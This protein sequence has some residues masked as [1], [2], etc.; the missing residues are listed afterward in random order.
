[1]PSS[2]TASAI[3][4][5]PVDGVLTIAFLEKP[6]GEGRFLLLQ[7]DL[8]ATLKDKAGDYLELDGKSRS[9]RCGIDA[10]VVHW[11]RLRFILNAEGR[12]RIGVNEFSVAHELKLV[13]LGRLYS[14]LTRIVGEDRVRHAVPTIE[15]VNSLLRVEGDD[16]DAYGRFDLFV[17]AFGRS[18]AVHIDLADASGIAPGSAAVI[19]D[20]VGMR[21][22]ARKKITQ[23]LHEH[24]L[25]TAREV[26]FPDPSIAA[27]PP[28][29]VERMLGRA[30]KKRVVAL[31]VDDPIHPCFL[32]HGIDSVEKK[33]TWTGFRISETAQTASR[34][35]VL[36]CRPQ[37]EPEHGVAIVIRDG[38]AVAA[39]DADVNVGDFDR[40]SVA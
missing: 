4:I 39:S 2:F 32:E 24:A 8:H 19:G 23:L 16:P 9:A 33:I 28:S 30:S 22:S 7:R 40:R 18:F 14:T 25:N 20:I 17:P 27:P 36:D 15:E 37:W 31:A 1:V 11:G 12:N 34:L 26:T 21:S 5:S 29:M 6:S 13:E 3:S 38:Q 10:V 35:C